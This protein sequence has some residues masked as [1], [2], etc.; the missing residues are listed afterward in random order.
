MIVN[1]FSSFDPSTSASISLNWI[2][3]L[4]AFIFIPV[5]LKLTPSLWSKVIQITIKWINKELEVIL[6][7]N[8]SITILIYSMFLFFLVSN[9]ISLFPYIFRVTRHL[10]I[11]MA[12]SLPIWLGTIFFGWVNYNK[13]IFGHMVPKGT[14][15]PL[16]PLIVL[17]ES[18]RNII[19]P[20]TLAIRLT[21]NVI[22]GHLLMTLLG[23][24]LA[25][26]EKRFIVIPLGAQFI[27]VALEIAV[28]TIQA[29][30]FSVLM[31]LYISEVNFN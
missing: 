18:M 25:H 14:P 31:T 19:R 21:A 12:V 29:Y 17:I 16:I 10:V 20:I 30:V 11:P 13:E 1:L 5:T 23:N 2:S 26:T 24:L 8:K 6:I 4:I 28:S 15:R 7:K 22:A 27:L 9:F 3:L